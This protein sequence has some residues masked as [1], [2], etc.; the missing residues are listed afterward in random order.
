MY[1]TICCYTVVTNILLLL[2][3]VGLIGVVEW[4]W[5]ATLPTLEPDDLSY[6]DYVEVAKE[7]VPKLQDEVCV[8][9]CMCVCVCVCVWLILK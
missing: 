4:E 3:Q 2:V 9:V 5:L 7:L 6:T 8:C 1:V